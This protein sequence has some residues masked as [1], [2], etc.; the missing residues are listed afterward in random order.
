MVKQHLRPPI[1]LHAVMLNYVSTQTALPL[2]IFKE[3]Y[4]DMLDVA[5]SSRSQ[6]LRPP[7]TRSMRSP[8]A[9]LPDR[10][11]HKCKCRANSLHPG[12]PV[13]RHDWQLI[14]QCTVLWMFIHWYKFT[15]WASRC[16]REHPCGGGVETS[17]VTLRVVG[18]DKKGTQCLGYN[19]STLFLGDIN[20]GIWPS[21]LGESRISDNKIWSW[22]SW[23]SDLRMTALARANNNCNRQTHPLIREDVT[24]EL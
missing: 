9:A 23:D 18:G 11:V 22:V 16:T 1:R 10:S 20:T 17:T 13:C 8:R 19:R 14:S 24:W 15:T 21:R 5:S 6:L 2:N 7:N 4:R 12:K 3:T